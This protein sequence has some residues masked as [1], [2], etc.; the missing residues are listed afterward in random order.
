MHVNIVSLLTYLQT[1]TGPITIH[2]AAKLS[3]Q[4]I[5]AVQHTVSNTNRS[6]RPYIIIIKSAVTKEVVTTTDST[7]IRRSLDA[8]LTRVTDCLSKVIKCTAK[9]PANRSHADLFIEAAVQHS[10]M[11][12]R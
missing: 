10:S 12:R 6:A 7:S 4:C 3:A 11:Q 2:C 5:T 1:E 9:K 8:R